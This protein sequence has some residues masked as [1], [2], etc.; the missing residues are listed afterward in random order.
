MSEHR[1]KSSA[2]VVHEV[3][4]ELAGRS[5]YLREA[6]P[7]GI[8]PEKFIAIAAR[9]IVEGYK[10]TDYDKQSIVS[11]LLKCADHRLLPDGREGA[12]VSFK[13][14][15]TFIPMVQGIIKRLIEG[16]NVKKIEAR[17]VMEGDDFKF[18][19]GL[20]P[21]L[22]HSPAAPKDGA[23]VIYAYAIAWI[24]G[25]DP[26]FDVMTRDEID[27]CRPLK[28]DKTP[29]RTH[30]GEMAK[31]T[32]IRRLAKRIPVSDDFIS[33]FSDEDKNLYS[34][35]KGPVTLDELR[36]PAS[37]A[38]D[39]APVGD[40]DYIDVVPNDTEQQ[41]VSSSSIL[42]GLDRAGPPTSQPSADDGF[43]LPP[44]HHQG[45]PVDIFQDDWTHP[46]IPA[47]ADKVIEQAQSRGLHQ[48]AMRWV[49]DG[50][51]AL[52]DGTWPEWRKENGIH[53]LPESLPYL[54]QLGQIYQAHSTAEAA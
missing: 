53:T 4:E 2:L 30:Y 46:D 14:Q 49:R 41:P 7:K 28:W 20:N 18:S 37:P 50:A 13:G 27:K 9:A 29:W 44:S 32:V 24:D 17:V 54:Q 6:L 42:S 5:D 40:D 45:G 1:G 47:L 22:D 11:A 16:G 38:P 25:A 15:L 43:H 8:S 23:K 10:I 39:T 35:P 51:Q 52:K 21:V 33:I 19:Y 34:E 48:E 26:T 31:K 3:K 12:L 36:N